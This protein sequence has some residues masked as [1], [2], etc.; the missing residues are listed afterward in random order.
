MAT[1]LSNELANTTTGL[2]TTVPVGYKPNAT[3]VGGRVK[4]YRATVT[5]AGQTTSD[6]I[7]LFNLPAGSTFLKGWMYVSA[8]LGS[9][10]IAIGNS[11]TAGKYR[12]AAAATTADSPLDFGV[13][14][15]IANAAPLAA[16]ETVLATIGGATLPSSGSM[17]V[18][19]LVAIPN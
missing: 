11:G 1:Y 15:A 17:V 6:V 2:S 3:A 14:A 18:V 19:I 5:L 13:T 9:S 7:Q 12:A 4:E 8:T 10:T 16:E